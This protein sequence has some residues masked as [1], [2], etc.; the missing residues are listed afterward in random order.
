[1]GVGFSVLQCVVC[2]VDDRADSEWD[3]S[4]IDDECVVMIQ[5]GVAGPQGPS[6]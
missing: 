2:Y 6:T 3:F 4:G 5:I 1:M